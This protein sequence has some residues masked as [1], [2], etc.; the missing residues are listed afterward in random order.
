MRIHSLDASIRAKKLVNFPAELH[1][2]LPTKRTVYELGGRDDYGDDDSEDLDWDMR[3]SSGVRWECLSDFT[4][5]DNGVDKEQCVEEAEKSVN[6]ALWSGDQV[7]L[8]EEDE[9]QRI[10]CSYGIHGKR[11]LEYAVGRLV[12]GGR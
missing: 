12:V 7:Y 6:E 8:R 1:V 3:E 4:D 11:K 9:L 10:S 5:L 2:D